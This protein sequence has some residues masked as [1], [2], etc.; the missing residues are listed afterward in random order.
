MKPIHEDTLEDRQFATTLARGLEV[1]RCFTPEE[2]FLGNKDLA[3]RTGLPR[4]TISRFTY[5][6][7]RL[8]YLRQLDSGKYQLGSA[9][10]SLGYPMLA[11]VRIRQVVRPAM[12]EMADLYG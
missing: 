9:T 10:V 7:V 4:P 8:G 2:P 12:N 6:L 11:R 1:L 3:E 5:T